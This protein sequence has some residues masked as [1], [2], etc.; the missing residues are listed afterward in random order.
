MN[1]AIYMMHHITPWY[2]YGVLNCNGIMGYNNPF[3]HYN[4][5]HHI[6]IIVVLGFI[7][8]NN[9]GVFIKQQKLIC[10]WH[11]WSLHKCHNHATSASEDTWT[12]GMI[13]VRWDCIIFYNWKCQFW[14]FMIN[15]IN[16]LV[17]DCI[18]IWSLKCQF[19][20]VMINKINGSVQEGSIHSA[21][22][23]EI[24]QSCIKSSISGVCIWYGPV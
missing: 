5:K 13:T 11:V 10:A 9:L 14:Y 1:N 15:N 21:L 20:Y 22:A 19:W 8:P 2:E 3:F 6:H 12:I 24:L 4:S 7:Y 16:G 17:Q 18:I 23:I